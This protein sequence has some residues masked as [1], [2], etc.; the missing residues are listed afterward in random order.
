M[1]EISLFRTRRSLALSKPAT[2][3][4]PNRPMRVIL[5]CTRS[6]HL[7]FLW[8][9]TFLFLLNLRAN[10]SESPRLKIL[11]YHME[12]FNARS[13]SGCNRGRH[14][15][16]KRCI[17]RFHC[18]NDNDSFYRILYARPACLPVQGVAEACAGWYRRSASFCNRGYCSIPQRRCLIPVSSQYR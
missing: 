13:T 16:R 9:S 6:R 10:F 4:T 7:P 2:P 11:V 17:L 12:S 5:I 8:W 14:R 3:F 1:E 18:R 15:Q